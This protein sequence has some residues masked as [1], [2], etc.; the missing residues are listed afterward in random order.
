[1]LSHFIINYYKNF[2]VISVID[3]SKSASPVNMHPS[4][5]MKCFQVSIFATK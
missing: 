4:A 5:I 2:G 1:M 3:I